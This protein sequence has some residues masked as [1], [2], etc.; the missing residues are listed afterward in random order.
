MILK[1]R[2]TLGWQEGDDRSVTLLNRM[3]TLSHRYGKRMIAY[4]PDPRHAE[5]LVKSFGLDDSR[6]RGVSTP[7]EEGERVKLYR[8]AAMRLGYIAQDVPLVQYAAN[9]V[10]KLMSKQSAD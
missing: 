6:A 8:S 9:K 4:E 3:I 10:A 1:K 7:G 5:L 2:A